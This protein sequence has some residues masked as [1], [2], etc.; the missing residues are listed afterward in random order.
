MFITYI[1]T[2]FGKKTDENQGS[3]SLKKCCI[4]NFG[5]I[6]LGYPLC[7]LVSACPEIICI[8]LLNVCQASSSSNNKTKI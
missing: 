1:T 6:W 5:I 3:V 8:Y 2:G 4:E 7:T